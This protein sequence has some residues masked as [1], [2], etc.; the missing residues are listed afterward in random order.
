MMCKY[1]Q[2]LRIPNSVSVR[3]KIRTASIVMLNYTGGQN[4]GHIKF[5]RFFKEHFSIIGKPGRPQQGPL[6][7]SA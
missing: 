7:V 1:V 4:A 3:A 5:R 6:S 2:G